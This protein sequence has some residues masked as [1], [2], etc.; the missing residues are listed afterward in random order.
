MLFSYVRGA[1]GAIVIAACANV[2]EAGSDGQ[3]SRGSSGEAPVAVVYVSID[4]RGLSAPP[5]FSPSPAM[6]DEKPAIQ[7]ES[8]QDLILVPLP[9]PLWAAASGLTA[10]A[11][12]GL[13]RRHRLRAEH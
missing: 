9:A 13:W 8:S 2:V 11:M 4:S 6:L 3:E 7:R 5:R 12:V 1:A 10:L